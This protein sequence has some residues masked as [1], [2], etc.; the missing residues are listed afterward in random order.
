M[1]TTHKIY[2]D[3]HTA[4][5]VTE[6][7][8]EHYIELYCRHRDSLELSTERLCSTDY[9]RTIRRLVEVLN[10]SVKPGV[11]GILDEVIAD[12]DIAIKVQSEED[13]K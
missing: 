2:E 7:S 8:S 13:I 5:S 1:S 3:E 6:Q 4:M 9:L 11:G 10:Y 12:L